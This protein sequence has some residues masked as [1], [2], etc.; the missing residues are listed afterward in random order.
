MKLGLKKLARGNL[1]DIK[2][3]HQAKSYFDDH[4]KQNDDGMENILSWIYEDLDVGKTNQ[5]RL[6]KNAWS[7]NN[8]DVRLDLCTSNDGYVKVEVQLNGTSNVQFG[9]LKFNFEEI[10]NY[11]M[12]SNRLPLQDLP[13]TLNPT[14]NLGVARKRALLQVH[15]RSYNDLAD[16]YN[17]IPKFTDQEIDSLN[18]VNR[19]DYKRLFD[20]LK[21]KEKWTNLQKRINEDKSGTIKNRKIEFG[22]QFLDGLI[23]SVNDPAAYEIEVQN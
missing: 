6:G 17:G 20:T 13:N 12:V 4:A 22:K 16:E 7:R 5:C 18:G 9:L 8:G 1:A 3:Y 21:F 15:M 14:N 11:V 19:D 23:K 2:G 10:K